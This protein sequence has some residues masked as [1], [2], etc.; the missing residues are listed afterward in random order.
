[1]CDLVGIGA[2][3]CDGGGGGGGGG[4]FGR[5]WGG[6]RGDG[7]RTCVCVTC[8]A[9]F[10]TI[11][12]TGCP[13]RGPAGPFAVGAN[14]IHNVGSRTRPCRPVCLNYNAES[15]AQEKDARASARVTLGHRQ[16][17]AES[18]LYHRNTASTAM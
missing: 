12:I 17:S 15:N 1:M 16:L 7:R 13:E 11:S 4:T 18:S 6:G 8:V 2:V 10:G 3:L 5:H 14:D 9:V